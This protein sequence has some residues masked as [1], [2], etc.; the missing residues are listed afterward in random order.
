MPV[1]RL[2]LHRCLQ[3]AAEFAP[4]VR[5]EAARLH[6]LAAMHVDRGRA[7]AARGA[8]VKSGGA[9]VRG[10][11]CI[12]QRESGREQ[13]GSSAR[14]RVPTRRV[15]TNHSDTVVVKRLVAAHICPGSCPRSRE[16]GES[17]VAGETFQLAPPLR[18]R[19]EHVRGCA[20]QRGR[21]NLICYVTRRALTNRAGARAASPQRARVMG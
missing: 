7:L 12:I 20:R 3:D 4:R 11:I 5:L 8:V 10:R 17:N 21:N 2:G 6:W 19:A 14:L 15:T 16:S 1:A 18:K 13:G 9:R